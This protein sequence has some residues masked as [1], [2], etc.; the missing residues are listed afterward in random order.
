MIQRHAIVAAALLATSLSAMAQTPPAAAQFDAT[1][2]RR[3][4]VNARLANQNARI[5]Q[6]KASGQISGAQAKQLHAQDHAIRTEER[7]DAAV[8]G[9]HITKGEQRTINHQEN[10]QS[11]DIGK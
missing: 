10:Q 4:E 3:A 2:P 6:E 11:R 7:A 9:G 8:N 5:D 1:H